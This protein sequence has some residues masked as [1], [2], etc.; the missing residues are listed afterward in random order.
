MTGSSGAAPARE[1]RRFTPENSAEIRQEIEAD[2]LR[3]SAARQ[4]GDERAELTISIGMGFGHYVTGGEAEA[5]PLLD[6]ALSQARQLGDRRA[7][8]EALL[9]LATARQYLGERE[10]AQSLFREAL[11]RSGAYSIPDF[12]HFILHHQGRC[13]A[14]QGDIAAARLSFTQALALREGLGIPRFID[15][16]RGAIVALDDWQPG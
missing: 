13:H 4:A 8:I 14:E 11:D 12:D 16:T 6:G 9:H 10:L 5:V 1:F 3:L 15:S 7:E 2:R